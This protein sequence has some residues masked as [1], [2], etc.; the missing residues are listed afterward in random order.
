MQND[1]AYRVRTLVEEDIPQIVDLFNKNKV[2]QF[3]NGAP[4]TLEDF[5][6]TLAIKETSHF[7][8]LEKNGKIIGTTAF[9]KFI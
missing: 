9:F 4:V 3:Q 5:C 8:V 6:L 7:Y 2:Y 1:S